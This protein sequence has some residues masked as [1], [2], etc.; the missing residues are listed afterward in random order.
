MPPTAETGNVLIVGA[1][2]TGLLL[3]GD[4]AAAG[5]PCAVLERREAETS[6]LTRAFAVHARTLELLD[7]RG[8]AEALAAT[9]ERVGALRLLG[10][11]ELDSLAAAEPVPV[12]AGD[13][14]VRDRAGAARSGPGRAAR[15][16]CTAPRSSGCGRTPAGVDVEVRASGGRRAHPPRVLRRRG[17][18]GAQ[19]RPAARWG[20]RSPAGRRCGR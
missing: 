19:H 16:S 6:N 13:A 14:A 12:R 7:A 20:C 15:R 10:V 5:I 3:A 2:P 17:R 9:G 11:R 4:L 1:G 18:R 8:I